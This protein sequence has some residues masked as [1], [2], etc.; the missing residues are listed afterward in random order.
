ML[1]A[2]LCSTLIAA[3]A[4]FVLGAPAGTDMKVSVGQTTAER[5]PLDQI[6]H[7]QWDGL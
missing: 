2:S 1:L 7:S 3:A 4:L 6:D 5:I